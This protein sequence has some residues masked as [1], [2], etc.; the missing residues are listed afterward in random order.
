MKK[1]LST[2]VKGIMMSC[3]LIFLF[4]PVMAQKEKGGEI[5]TQDEIRQITEIVKPLRDQL[6]KQLTG[7][8]TYNAYVEDLKKIHASTNVKEKSNLTN[9]V[10][11]KYTGFFK[12]LWSAAKVD[13]QSYQQKIRRVF[14]GDLGGLLQ[15]SDFLD[16][17]L[18]TSSTPTRT[19][20]PNTPPSDK[21]LDVCS[22]ATGDITSGSAL[23]AD[24]G[25]VWGNCFLRTYAWGVTGNPIGAAEANGHLLNNIRIPGTLA[26]DGRNLRVNISYDLRQDVTCLS[27][28]GGGY[29][30][31]R[32]IT[33]QSNEGLVAYA[34]L[35]WVA[36][37]AKNKSIV[38]NYVL[39]KK[40]VSLSSFWSHSGVVSILGS[41]NWC[42]S[43]CNNI[44]WTICEEK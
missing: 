24:A 42:S 15:F 39:L 18:I 28:I 40:N 16:F 32:L 11:Q 34:P 7:N 44:K 14:P 19:I 36:H 37:A 38:E 5:I 6:E 17:T 4:F 21:C 23:V 22:M 27:S 25:G 30:E 13:E 29:A 31:T 9:Q 20:I 43:D 35:I 41:G 33:F 1:Q 10:I 3:L 8:A 12:E 26:D 2:I